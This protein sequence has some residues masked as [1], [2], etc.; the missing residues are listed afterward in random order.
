MTDLRKDRIALLIVVTVFIVSRLLYNSDALALAAPSFRGN[1]LERAAA[2][3]RGENLDVSTLV[4]GMPLLDESLLR[5]DLWRSLL[6]LHSQPPLFNLLVAGM[7]RLSGTLAINYQIL[8]W[9]LGLTLYVLA[10][11]LMRALGAERMPASVMTIAFMLNPNAMW[12]EGAIYYGVVMAVL[13]AGAAWAFWRALLTESSRWFALCVLLL[14]VIPLTR[15]FFAVPWFLAMAVFVTWAYRSSAPRRRLPRGSILALGLAVALVLGFQVKQRIMFGQ[16]VGSSWLGCN[17]A[18]MTAG[19]SREKQI[20]LDRGEVSPLVHVYRNAAVPAYEPYFDVQL[21]GIPALDE[22]WKKGEV[23]PNFNHQIYIP[24]GRQYLADTLHLIVRS[25][26]KYLLNVVNS[27]YIFSGYQIGVYFDYPDRFF[28]RWTWTEILAP[29]IGFPLI[30]IALVTGLR[31]IRHSPHRRERLLVAFMLGNIVYV[32]LVSV[33][34]EKSEGP[35]YRYQIDAFLYGLLALALTDLSR[36]ARSRRN[37][38]E[39][40]S[41]EPPDVRA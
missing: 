20:A 27:V 34:L 1:L 30:V 5:N 36:W 33:L 32:I 8:N 24:V 29:L 39:G 28:A 10:F 7:L 6:Y 9:A 37:D 4:R 3:L 23:D 41:G 13:L 40:R 17:L 16:W 14:A 25:P 35:V 2:S 26:H 15:A 11:H 18:T 38:P 31:R 21:T 12:M 22:P 19:M